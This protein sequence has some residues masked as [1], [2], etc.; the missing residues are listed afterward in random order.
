MAAIVPTGPGDAF[1]ICWLDGRAGATSDYG[2]GGTSLYWAD[3]SGESF[4]PEVLLDPRVC[5]CCKTSAAPGAQGPLV[6]YRDRE[7][8]ERRDISVVRRDGATWSAPRPVRG[9]GWSLSACPTNGPAIAAVG[10]RASVAWFT[11]ADGTPSVWVSASADG[12]RRFHDAIRID[13]S[14][15]VAWLERD[16]KNAEIRVRRVGPDGNAGP[17]VVVANTSPARA[18]GYPSIAAAGGTDVVVAWIDTGPPSRVKAATI[19]L[20]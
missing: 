9:D 19:T 5:D 6:A 3:H 4:G 17:P 10:E 13:G 18:S 16:G 14:T 20:R 7:P 11:G 2:E 12:G 8:T 1:G 15:A